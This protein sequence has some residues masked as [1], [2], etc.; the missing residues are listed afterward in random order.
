MKS[1]VDVALSSVLIPGLIDGDEVKNV[2]RFISGIDRNIPY[3]IIGYMPVNG[4]GYRR[5]GY[6]ELKEIADSIS[7]SLDNVIFS[8]PVP[9][10]YTGIIDLFTNNLKK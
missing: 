4:F 2:A 9:Q 1:G 3:R 6:R 5:P 8:D 10:D 7:G